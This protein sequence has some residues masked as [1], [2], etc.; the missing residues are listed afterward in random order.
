MTPTE[1][2]SFRFCLGREAPAGDLREAVARQF[3]GP[4]PDIWGAGTGWRRMPTWQAWQDSER[5]LHKPGWTTAERVEMLAR[6][7]P[8]HDWQAVFQGVPNGEPSVAVKRIVRGL[9]GPGEQDYWGPLLHQTQ[10]GDRPALMRVLLDEQNRCATSES[11]VDDTYCFWAHTLGAYALSPYSE[12]LEAVIIDAFMYKAYLNASDN[13]YSTKV[14]P[15]ENLWRELNEVLG[16]GPGIPGPDLTEGALLLTGL[17]GDGFD[18]KW[19]APGERTINWWKG[20]EI[21][22]SQTFGPSD[23]TTAIVADYLEWMAIQPEVARYQV[24]RL[25]YPILGRNLTERLHQHL[26]DVWMNN[27]GSK[28]HVLQAMAHHDDAWAPTRKAPVNTLVGL[29]THMNENA[30]PVPAYPAKPINWKKQI[31][32]YP[33]YAPNPEGYPLGESVMRGSFLSNRN[34]WPGTPEQRARSTA[35]DRIFV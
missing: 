33:E 16:G 7:F 12:Y 4:V 30:I 13:R 26:T 10:T 15:D 25:V 9:I 2:Y 5:A 32:F 28:R 20:D 35:A 21:I 19:Q 11:V 6:W 31:G 23:G 8:E 18:P 24:W 34:E 14:P 17:T 27:N 3:D 29:V 1:I 22:R